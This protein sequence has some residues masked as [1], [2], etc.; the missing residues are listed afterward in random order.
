MPRQLPCFD[1]IDVALDTFHFGPVEVG[2]GDQLLGILGKVGEESIAAGDVE[3]TEDVVDEENRFLGVVSLGE[4][5]RLSQLQSEGESAL[6]SLRAEGAGWVAV[7]LECEFVAVRTDDGLTAP[8]VGLAGFFKC[9]RQRPQNGFGLV[10]DGGGLGA[11]AEAGSSIGDPRL[12]ESDE[13]GATPEEDFAVLHEE[14][15]V[16]I[17]LRPRDRHI[18]E[19]IVSGSGGP[20]IAAQGAKVVGED[21]RANK[22]EVAPPTLPAPV[23]ELEITIAHPDY[24]AGATQV[25]ACLAGGRPVDRE[26]FQAPPVSEVELSV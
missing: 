17:D 2:G 8:G 13:L 7:D 6:L 10:G 24:M 14:Q 22:V 25:V 21:L 16:G 3:L 4:E 5:A 11:S 19:K 12:E 18:F 20:F 26:F 1:I 23:N 9:P 15:S